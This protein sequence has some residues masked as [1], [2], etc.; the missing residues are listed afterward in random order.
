MI[1]DGDIG[2]LLAFDIGRGEAIFLIG[3]ACHAA[4]APLVK[5][6]NRGEPLVAFTLWSLIA[7]GSWI[8]LYG[9]REIAATDWTALPAVVWIAIGYLSVFTTAGTTFL[10][11][12]A[13]MRLPASKVLAYTYLT[14]CYIILFEGLLGHGWAGPS[15]AA[16][17]LVTV[18]GLVVLALSRDG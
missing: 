11:Q 14:P 6:F 9:V 15:V 17:A 8:A 2:A 16:G 1:F 7:T 10:V 12:F 3:C 13:A 4:Y 5:R 18:L